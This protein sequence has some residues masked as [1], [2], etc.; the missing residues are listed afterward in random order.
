MALIGL[1]LLGLG[2]FRRRT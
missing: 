2:V 1:G